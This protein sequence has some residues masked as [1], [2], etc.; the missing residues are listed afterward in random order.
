MKQIFLFLSLFSS[1][2]LLR[3]ATI[4]KHV[5]NA[6]SGEQWLLANKHLKVIICAR[7]GMVLHLTDKKTGKEGIQQ[8]L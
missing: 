2:F 4:E 6:G 1:L 5:G 3:A 8:S 7:G